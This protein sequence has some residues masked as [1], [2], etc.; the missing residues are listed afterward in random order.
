MIVPVRRHDPEWMDRP[1]NT[2]AELE[3]ALHD[4]RSVNRLLGGSKTLVDAIL[5]HLASAPPERPLTILDVGTGGADVPVAIAAAAHRLGRSVRIVG[6]DRDAVTIDLARRAVAGHGEIELV[7]ADAF[8]FEAPEASFDLV[9]ASLFL[10]HFTHD[11][12][13]RLVSRFRGLARRAV[14][15][16]DLE[17]HLV[18]WA[19]IAV[20]ARLTRRH[21]MF[22]HDAPLSVLR[23]FTHDELMHVAIDAGAPLATVARRW[24]F[25]LLMTVPA[26]GFTS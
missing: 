3:G 10:H 23:G 5:P 25:R 6:I 22:V 2:P 26:R 19:F 11:D 20:A 13:T 15:V 1:D 14:L 9:T 7:H 18:P 4:I 17:R 8:T 12:A 24:P 21:A 16:N